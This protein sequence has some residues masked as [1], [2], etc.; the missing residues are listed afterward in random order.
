MISGNVLGQLALVVVYPIITRLYSP[1]LMGQYGLF[2]SY[3]SVASVCVCL[4]YEASIVA[5]KTKQTAFSILMLSVILCVIL[6]FLLFGGYV[7]FIQSNIFGF[8]VLPL[9][10]SVVLLFMLLIYG[11]YSIANYFIIREQGYKDLARVNALRNIIKALIQV[12]LGFFSS[13]IGLVL[14]DFLGRLVGLYELIKKAHARMG[15]KLKFSA[16]K[17]LGVASKNKAYPIY[18]LPSSLINTLSFSLPIPFISHYYGINYAGLYALVNTILSLPTSLITSAVADVFHGEIAGLA[19]NNPTEVR[20]LFFRVV[21]VLFLVAIVPTIIGMFLSP[22]LFSFIFGKSWGEAGIIASILLPWICMLFIVSPV[23]R[24]V[25]VLG[26]ER[27]KLIY[28]V[29]SL[30]AVV[31]SFYVG[32][33]FHFSLLKTMVIFSGANVITCIIYYFILYRI[34]D[35]FDVNVVIKS[36][37]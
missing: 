20:G 21:K 23:S 2:T 22:Y 37:D 3:L 30:F 28:D 9:Y 19:R 1:K 32:G 29:L 26:G 5:A 17:L 11:F 33:Y 4:R 15:G 8:K 36:N 31:G 12:F 16:S 27:T 13:F 34:I 10:S 35:N 24:L 25:F 14:G 18:L 6:S 7:W